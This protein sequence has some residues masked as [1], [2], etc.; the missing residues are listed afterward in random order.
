MP[1]LPINYSNTH[2]YKI[3]CKNADTKDC[4]VGHTTDFKR[5]KSEHKKH[6]NLETYKSHYNLPVYRFIRENGGWDIWDMI[7]I[8]TEECDNSLHARQRE[9]YYLENENSTLNRVVPSRPYAEMLNENKERYL[10]Y[11]RQ[12][13][14]DNIEKRKQQAKEYRETHKKRKRETDKRYRE[15]NHEKIQDYHKIYRQNHIEERHHYLK[16]TYTCSC[17]C[18][19]RKCNKARHERSNKHQQS[20]E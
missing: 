5:R 8:K 10:A 18:E 4:Y 3:V 12:Y 9:R 2:F 6:C 13:Y 1:N 14:Y 15:N 7:L 20:F 16:E 17:G 11:W 19:V